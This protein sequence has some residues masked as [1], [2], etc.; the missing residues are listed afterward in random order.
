[1]SAEEVR[2]EVSDRLGTTE[3]SGKAAVGFAVR[4]K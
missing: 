1:M 4:G 3:L 2:I